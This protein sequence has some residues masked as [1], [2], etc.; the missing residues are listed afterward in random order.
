MFPTLKHIF[1]III[2]TSVN[3]TIGCYTHHRWRRGK[4]RRSIKI[5]GKSEQLN[6]NDKIGADNIEKLKLSGLIQTA[7]SVLLK[8]SC[9]FFLT[10]FPVAGFLPFQ[11]LELETYLERAPA[12]LE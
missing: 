1:F 6:L 10:I 7:I 11:F 8:L 5:K 12:L 3:Q 4:Y 2:Q 9:L